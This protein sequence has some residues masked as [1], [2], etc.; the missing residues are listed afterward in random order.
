MQNMNKVEED[1]DD[2]R[3]HYAVSHGRH[4]W[5][6]HQQDEKTKQTEQTVDLNTS[7]RFYS[8]ISC[9]TQ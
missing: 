4:H 3:L 9:M 6:H 8:G 5:L 1:A 2:P 7:Y